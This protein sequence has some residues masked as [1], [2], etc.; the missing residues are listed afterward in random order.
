MTREGEAT[1][2]RERER[3][4]ER[5]GSGERERQRQRRWKPGHNTV[6]KHKLKCEYIIVE[7]DGMYMYNVYIMSIHSNI[8][9][10]AFLSGILL[11]TGGRIWRM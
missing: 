5:T 6:Y 8:H 2:E 7:A 3:E 1:R 4:R 10:L 9:V 11:T